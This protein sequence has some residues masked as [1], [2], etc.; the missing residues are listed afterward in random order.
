[1][2]GGAV[3]AVGVRSPRSGRPVRRDAALGQGTVSDYAH[4]EEMTGPVTRLWDV[5]VN[6][7]AAHYGAV[8]WDRP[9]CGNPGHHDPETSTRR[10]NSVGDTATKNRP[11]A[12]ILGPPAAGR[13]GTVVSNASLPWFHGVPRHPM[14][15]ERTARG[16]AGAR[17]G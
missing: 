1:M 10:P 7:G 5:R 17:L 9:F 11:T 2:G 4:R 6:C 15:P 3:P 16:D 14:P 8:G 12:P 13:R